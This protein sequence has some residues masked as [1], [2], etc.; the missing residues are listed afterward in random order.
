M[1]LFPTAEQFFACLSL[2]ARL[3]TAGGLIDDLLE[4]NSLYY[5]FDNWI[6]TRSDGRRESSKKIKE[7][8]N[9]VH[10]LDIEDGGPLKLKMAGRKSLT[11][12]K[13]WLCLPMRA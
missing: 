5:D 8:I 12:W 7:Q 3:N 2:I 10:L 9:K 4:L 1:H 6:I 13:P 11:S